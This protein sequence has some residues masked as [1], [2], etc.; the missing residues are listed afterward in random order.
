[1]KIK[2]IN[3]KDALSYLIKIIILCVT[4]TVF[5]KLLCKN[6]NTKGS[7]QIN[8]SNFLGCIKEEITVFKNNSNN[9]KDLFEMYS[10]EALSNELSLA[11]IISTKEKDNINNKI[12]NGE[13]YINGVISQDVSKNNKD[14]ANTENGKTDEQLVNSK[15][16]KDDDEA[17]TEQKTENQAGNQT[18]NQTNNQADNQVDNQTEN[19]IENAI[20]NEANINEPQ[21]RSTNRNTSIQC[22]R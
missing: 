8:T 10:K 12:L 6:K 16:N 15:P 9:C 1:M 5:C 18:E 2:V 4:I 22:S 3:F 7:L 17:E 21:T 13:N 11:K 14:G 20:G 19:E